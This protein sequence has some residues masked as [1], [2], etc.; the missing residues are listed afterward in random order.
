MTLADWVRGVLLHSLEGPGEPQME[1]HIFTELVGIQMLL[2]N[3]LEPLL[4]GDKFAPGTAH[5]PLSPSPDDQGREG[6]GTPRQAQPEQGEVAMPAVQQW[7]RNESMIW[8]PALSLHPQRDL[9]LAGQ[10]LDSLSTSTS[11]LALR[12][13]NATTCRTISAARCQVSRIMPALITYSMFPMVSR[14]RGLRS[15]PT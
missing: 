1:M 3:T 13:S 5:H 8:P 14:G 12:R 9:S 6:A 2:M 4:R 7:G 10:R 15:K 11:N